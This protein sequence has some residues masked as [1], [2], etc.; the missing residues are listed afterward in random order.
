[1]SMGTG[2]YGLSALFGG[3]RHINTMMKDELAKV[4]ELYRLLTSLY[5]PSLVTAV[6]Q[7]TPSL[8]QRYRAPAGKNFEV[9]DSADTPKRSRDSLSER[10]TPS[11]KARRQAHLPKETTTTVSHNT[12]TQQAENWTVVQSRQPNSKR[13]KSVQQSK[14]KRQIKPR[15]D[16]ILIEAKGDTSYSDILKMVTR[17]QNEKLQSVIIRA[18]F[19][20]ARTL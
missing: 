4:I 7:T 8:A 16:A 15:P 2:L 10:K 17:S 9:L 12:A 3:Q 18:I 6:V 19:K 13:A 11:K 1:M 20:L 5:P 14:N